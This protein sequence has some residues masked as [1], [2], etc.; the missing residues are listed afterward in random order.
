MKT[1]NCKDCRHWGYSGTGA[2]DRIDMGEKAESDGAAINADAN[3]D[4]GLFGRLVTG[5]MFGCTLFK[6]KGK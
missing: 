2:C 5:P 4:C 3:D 6:E 1:G